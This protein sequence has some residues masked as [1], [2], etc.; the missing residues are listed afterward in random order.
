MFSRPPL[1]YLINFTKNL[2]VMIASGISLNESLRSLEAQG[3]PRSF[4]AAIR[5]LREKVEAGTSLSQALEKQRNIFG[6]I[7]IGLVK[8]GETSGTLEENLGFAAEW[9]ERE[10]DLRKEIK[11]ATLYPKIILLVSFLLAGVMTVFVLPKLIPLFSQLRVELP[12]STRHLIAMSRFME[13]FWPAVGSFLFAAFFGFKFLKKYTPAARLMDTAV[14]KI[15]VLGP[16]VSDYQLALYSRLL[17]TLFK[18]GLSMQE[19]LGIAAD[20]LPNFVYR[21]SLR[22][23]QERVV[24]GT[25][26]ARALGDQGNLYPRLMRDIVETGERSGTLEQSFS[27]LAE[28]YL[29]EVSQKT[30]KLP[31]VLE[32]LL[33]IFL[34][35]G[36]LF[37]AFSILAPIYQL[38]HGFSP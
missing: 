30:K 15:P 25:S 16:I 37:V 28:F 10:E 12:A 31:V 7:Y 22:H 17:F 13:R 8:A 23:I 2:R 27:Y 1:K 6:D 19:S 32:P 34:A 9:M 14:L 21:S 36:V 35:G 38:T 3:G 24:K 33:L 20:A 26:L 5:T 18:S 4:L 29:K 11:A